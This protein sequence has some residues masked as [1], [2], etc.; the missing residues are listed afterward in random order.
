MQKR[1]D[2]FYP[3]IQSYP[4][5]ANI[6]SILAKHNF[7]YE[8]LYSNHVQ[9]FCATY[10][11]YT[12]FD[13]YLDTY[14]PLNRI[15]YP[16][17][18]KHSINKLLITSTEVD[19]CDFLIN[20]IDLG[21]YIYLSVDTFYIPLYKSSE[22]KIHDIF[23]F[24]YDTDKRFF[25]VA[26]FFQ[27]NYSH[28]VTSFQSIVQSIKS[29]YSDLNVFNEIQFLKI[30]ENPIN[31]VYHFD[32]YRLKTLLND[33]L[34]AYNTSK[35]YSELEGPLPDEDNRTWGVAVYNS[36]LEALN[37]ET[38]PSVTLRSLHALY[39][40][41]KLMRMRVEFLIEKKIIESSIALL[42][43]FILLENNSLIIRNVFLKNMYSKNINTQKHTELISNI[44]KI[45][46]ECLSSLINLL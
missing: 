19:I 30:N 40:H 33:Y 1:L 6:T 27:I 7:F 3:I 39:E 24:G 41:K 17:L 18:E 11:E 45:E 38:L 10:Q 13:T 8:W 35:R 31:P 12:N 5:H 2:M 4:K 15:F 43:D 28:E 46:E 14:E 21:Y 44:K 36:L 16:L 20:C 42:D 32:I 23:I 22:H 34:S 25:N 29:T 37:V 9:L 26:D